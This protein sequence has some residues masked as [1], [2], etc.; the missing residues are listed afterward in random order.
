MIS[1]MGSEAC[2]P[3]FYILDKFPDTAIG[4]HLGLWLLGIQERLPGPGIMIMGPGRTGASLKWDRNTLIHPIYR[5]G[6]GNKEK[7]GYNL[8]GPGVRLIYT[9]TPNLVTVGKSQIAVPEYAM[10]ITFRYLREV[11]ELGEHIAG[12]LKAAGIRR[13]LK[14]IE[15]Y[16]KWKGE[17]AP[18]VFELRAVS[19]GKYSF[20]FFKDRYETTINELYR[21][22]NP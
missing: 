4:G 1:A 7:G 6:I 10:L 20:Y 16:Y 11:Y 22:V 12:G 8:Q 18:P 21:I 15:N 5:K 2:G 17:Y 14:L 9:Y 19:R 3:I 13:R